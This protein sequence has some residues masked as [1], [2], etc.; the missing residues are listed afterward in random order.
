ME[1]L[2]RFWLGILLSGILLIVVGAT[3]IRDMPV[4]TFCFLFT[5]IMLVS[6]GAGSRRRA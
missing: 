3:V 4:Y 5:G 1:K 2:K 6:I